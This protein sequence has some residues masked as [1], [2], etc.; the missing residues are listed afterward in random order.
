MNGKLLQIFNKMNYKY[1]EIIKCKNFK[2][3]RCSRCGKEIFGICTCS[4]NTNQVK[5]P[6]SNWSTTVTICRKCGARYNS[7]IHICNKK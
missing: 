3:A 7:N 5:Q 6:T 2:M 1:F 4:I